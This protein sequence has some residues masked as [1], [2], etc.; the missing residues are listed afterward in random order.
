MLGSAAPAEG[1][2]AGSRVGGF[3][4]PFYRKTGLDLVASHGYLTWKRETSAL[5][6]VVP[7][8]TLHP[9]LCSFQ[10]RE[11]EVMETIWCFVGLF[12]VSLCFS[13]RLMFA[14]F[15]GHQGENR[16]PPSRRKLRL[17]GDGGVFC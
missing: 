13:A 14:F 1:H 7:A 16:P 3:P 15:I 5:P 8:G 12:R 17:Q 11:H 6:V 10:P 9:S 4:L 2:D